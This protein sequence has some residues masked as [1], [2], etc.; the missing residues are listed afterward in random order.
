MMSYLNEAEIL[1]YLMSSDFNEGLTQDECRFLLLR[2]RYHFRLMS[3]RNQSQKWLIDNSEQEIANL[4]EQIENLNA[5]IKDLEEKIET[6][7]NR[8]LT[9]QERLKGKKIK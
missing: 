8:K 1:D 5:S 6:E 4:K 7:Q 9:W 3:S 2:F